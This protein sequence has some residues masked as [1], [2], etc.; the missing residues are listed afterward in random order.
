MTRM[1]V[2]AVLV[3]AALVAF[4]CSEGSGGN[5]VTPGS[6]QSLTAGV[7]REANQS[8]TYLWGYYQLFFDFDA[9]E[10]EAVVDRSAMFALN[11]VTFLNNKPATLGFNFNTIGVTPDFVDVDLDVSITHPIPSAPK[12]NGYDVRGVLICEGSRIMAYNPELRC[13]ILGVDQYMMNAD[14]YTRWF[15]L[16]EFTHPGIFG[17]TEGI[18][19]TK[20]LLFGDATVNP[21][22][23]FADG[24]GLGDEAFQFLIDNSASHGVFSSGATNSRNYLIRFPRPVPGI[25]YGYSVVANW[26]SGTTHP[27]NAPEAVGCHV[28]IT[29]NIYYISPIQWGG[30]LILDLSLFDWWAQPADI[31]LESTVLA[32]VYHFDAMDMTPIGGGDQYSTYHVEIPADNVTS[33]AG[34]EFWIIAEF[35]PYD[36]TNPFGVPNAADT[37]TL[38]AFFR[39][40]LYVSEEPYNE[41]PVIT[42]GVDGY[43]TAAWDSVQD[44]VVFAYD[45]NDDPLTYS[46]TAQCITTTEPEFT[47]PGDGYGGLTLDWANDIGATVGQVFAIDCEVSDPHWPPVSASTLTVTITETQNFPP[48]IVSGVNGN[49]EAGPTSV[50]AY[51]VDA[52]D[53]E[54]DPLTYDWGVR[55]AVSGDIVFSG[56]GDGAGTFVVDWGNDVGASEGESYI[57]ECAV[58]D[59]Y[60]QPIHA[61]PLPVQIVVV[62]NQDPVCDLVIMGPN[63]GYGYPYAVMEFD[64]SGSYDPDFGD[65]LTYEWDFNNDLVFG[66][67]HDGTPEHAI[68]TF[69]SDFKHPVRVRV[70]DGNG[71]QDQCE[72]DVIAF[73]NTLYYYEGAYSD[74]GIVDGTWDDPHWAFCPGIH[75]W[76]EYECG[77]YPD[78]LL[79]YCRTPYIQFP[80]PGTFT[81]LHLEIWHWGDMPND[82]STYADLGISWYDEVSGLD[83]NEENSWYE[84]LWY[85]EGLDFNDSGG[86]DCFG[87]TFGSESSPAWSH[88]DCS[89]YAGSKWAISPLFSAATSGGAYDGWNL[90]KMVVW[91]E[92]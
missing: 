79:T 76:D 38:A 45:P 88:F 47:G 67:P 32:T 73:P 27:A 78:G 81:A 6:D 43:P 46:W 91:V 10:V 31:Y 40:D 87:G 66:D 82:G 14:G 37:D 60:S 23:Y 51:T 8:Q 30:R 39:Y 53:P 20:S 86:W 74:G 70:S 59:P 13:P 72:V 54:D 1:P 19:A 75:A 42:S 90:R 63:P 65:I 62:V 29:D 33:T 80:E 89:A 61:M 18:Y 3:I 52:T 17:Y 26:I 69:T 2:I 41:P 92:P 55:E 58:T 49:P 4:G 7:S 48:H 68:Y 16:P 83:V 50:K 24:I 85:I 9:G 57:I 44:Y 22:K 28:D 11:V 56:P 64:A 77:V 25:K 34:N 36:Y 12:L 21:Y 84:R 15:N 71:G 35:P 5:P